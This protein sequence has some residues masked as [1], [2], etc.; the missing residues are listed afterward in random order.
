MGNKDLKDLLKMEIPM[1]FSNIGMRMVN[2]L[3]RRIG[4]MEENMEYL[5]VGTRMGGWKGRRIILRT[6]LIMN[7]VGM[8]KE[9][10]I[11]VIVLTEDQWNPLHQINKQLKTHHYEKTTYPFLSIYNYFWFS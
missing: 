2:Y 7:P 3:L 4:K 9:K 8:Q 5:K 6:L 11:S 10:S 1:E